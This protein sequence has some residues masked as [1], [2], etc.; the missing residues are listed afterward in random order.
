MQEDNPNRNTPAK[1]L[2]DKCKKICA[3]PN[4][5][6]KHMCISRCH[7]TIPN[8]ND[9]FEES[10]PGARKSIVSEK[11]K[12]DPKSVKNIVKYGY[13]TASEIH[14]QGQRMLTNPVTDFYKYKKFF[15]D[16][17]KKIKPTDS[18]ISK[19]GKYIGIGAVGIIGLPFYTVGLAK[20]AVLA[21]Y[22]AAKKPLVNIH[23]SLQIKKRNSPTYQSDKLPV[24]ESVRFRK[25][26][27]RKSKKSNRTK[28]TN[29]SNMT[30][31]TNKS[32]M[33]KRTNKSKRTKR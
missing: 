26:Y 19:I 11:L 16:V 1:N 31:R 29:K 32:K 25:N 18:T 5:L 23:N 15:K 6:L 10:T 22:Y 14:S 24:T 2:Y 17:I 9:T 33:S 8:L 12:K 28:R 7:Q 21:P 27:R 4:I 13:L 20:D 30:K 3:K